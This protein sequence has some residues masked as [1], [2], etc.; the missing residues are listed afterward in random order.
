MKTSSIEKSFAIE[1]ILTID[2][3][4]FDISSNASKRISWTFFGSL[5]D[6]TIVKYVFHQML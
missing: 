3:Q 2:F 6:E 4:D 5:H 1:K